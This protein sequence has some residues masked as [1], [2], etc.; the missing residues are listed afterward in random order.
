MEVTASSPLFEIVL[1]LV[2]FDHV[3]SVA[4]W[5]T[6]PDQINAAFRQL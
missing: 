4:L 6:K 5:Y 1:V 3:A 2:C